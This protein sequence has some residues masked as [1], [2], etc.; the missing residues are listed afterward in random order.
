MKLKDDETPVIFRKYSDGEILALF[1]S[2]PGDM[3][4]W[5]CLS[6]AHIGQHGTADYLGVIHNTKLAKQD[7]YKDLYDELTSIGY[8][9]KIYQRNNILFD[10]IRRM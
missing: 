9:L 10:T 5:N 2:L 7:E 3:D 6:Y 4:F 8:D 1:P